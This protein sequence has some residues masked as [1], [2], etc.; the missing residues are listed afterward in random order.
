MGYS[1]GVAKSQP[2]LN[3]SASSYKVN[4]NIF[5]LD[6]SLALGSSSLGT[7]GKSGGMAGSVPPDGV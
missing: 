7:G 2:Q 5:P 1:P 6:S 4:H 3:T